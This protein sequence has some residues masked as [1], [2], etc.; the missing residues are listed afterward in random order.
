[1]TDEKR[2]R[3]ESELD[4]LKTK[5]MKM[6]ELIDSLKGINKEFC[7]TCEADSDANDGK[8]SRIVFGE[9]YDKM[10][11]DTRKILADANMDLDDYNIMSEL[12]Y[13]DEEVG[14]NFMCLVCA[15][16]AS[17]YKHRYPIESFT[18]MLNLDKALK[19]F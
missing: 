17:I 16:W 13:Q 10:C 19:M 12:M 3:L 18:I 4:E 15:E 6:Y 14:A 7:D 9:A 11:R 8:L 1:M 2:K 5:T